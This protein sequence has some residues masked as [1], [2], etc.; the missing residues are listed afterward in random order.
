MENL[1]ELN[2]KEVKRN[3]DYGDL[4]LLNYLKN[5]IQENEN[6][7]LYQLYKDVYN[8]NE[9]YA[10]GWTINKLFEIG[11]ED[12]YWIE[13]ANN[14][15]NKY[16][17]KETEYDEYSAFFDKYIE[18]RNKLLN[19][20]GIEEYILDMDINKIP[21]KG[22]IRFDIITDINDLNDEDNFTVARIL[23]NCHCVELHYNEGEPTIEYGIKINYD[24]WESIV[25]DANWFS[26]K[27]TEN[28]LLNKLEELFKDYYGEEEYI[29]ENKDNEICSML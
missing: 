1:Y 29:L 21:N 18:L 9:I 4:C 15:I 20:L 7:T 3:Y 24:Y 28:E 8:Y 6:D 14:F 11:K 5:F 27:I 12:N 13:R 2:L 17:I 22:F 25:E 19:N 23:N 26:K 16:N 10:N